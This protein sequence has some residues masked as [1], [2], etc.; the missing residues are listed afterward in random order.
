MVLSGTLYFGND[1]PLIEI[2]PDISLPKII[3]FYVAGCN[4]AELNSTFPDLEAKD[5]HYH[6]YIKVQCKGYR[7]DVSI[8]LKCGK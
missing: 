1:K 3:V 7:I 2:T 4:F 5:W 8:Q 6:F